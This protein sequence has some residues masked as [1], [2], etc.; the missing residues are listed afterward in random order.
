MRTHE[1]MA[2]VLLSPKSQGPEAH[3]FM[4]R[5]GNKKGNITVWQSGRV[6]DEYIKT[7]GHYHVSDFEEVY[8]VLAGEGILLLQ[9]RKTNSDGTPVDDEVSAVKAIFVKKGNKISIPKRAGHMMANIGTDWLVTR[10]NSPLENEMREVAAWPM[11]ADYA[12]I[13]K[14]HGFAY[15][16]VDKD[17]T[18][19]FV[20]NPNYKNTPELIIEEKA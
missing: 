12:P 10:D 1:E 8:E 3:Y 13:K 16:I 20:K 7:Y 11:H 6:G 14:L 4:I 15:Y 2:D 9:E 19:F 17:G 18:P 5:G